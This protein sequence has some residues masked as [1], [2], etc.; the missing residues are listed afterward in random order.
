MRSYQSILTQED[1]DRLL[2]S[3]SGFHDSMTKEI[4][5]T[6]RAYV[7]PDHSM[8]MDHRYD[9]Q[10]LTSSCRR[11]ANQNEVQLIRHF[12]CRRIDL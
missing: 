4:H 11:E 8:D 12:C 3:I 9:A 10:V 1:M 2:D 5:L 6:N 7:N